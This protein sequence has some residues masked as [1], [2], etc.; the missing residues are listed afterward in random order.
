M[1]S[2]PACP[3]FARRDRAGAW[4]KGIRSCFARALSALAVAGLPNRDLAVVSCDALRIVWLDWKRFAEN[5]GKTLMRRPFDE[6]T[7][8]DARCHLGALWLIWSGGCGALGLRSEVDILESG[9]ECFRRC[10]GYCRCIT[11]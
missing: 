9:S 2:I 1:G 11:K 5:V 3:A 4:G 8:R 10:V 6:S 7:V